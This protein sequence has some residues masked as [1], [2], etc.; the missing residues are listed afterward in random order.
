MLVR[1]L[2]P[3]RPSILAGAL[4]LLPATLDAQRVLGGGDDAVTLPRGAF[5]VELGGLS[6]LQR[7]RWID[8]R[9]EGLGGHLTADAFGP[10]QFSLLAPVEQLVRDLGVP[11]FAASLGA[12]RLDARQRLFVTPLTIEYGLGARVTVGAR[13]TLVRSRAQAQWRVRGDSGRATLGMNPILAGSAVAVGNATTIGAYASA[14]T[15]L[16]ARRTACQGNPAAA[17]ECPTILAELGAVDALIATTSG[18]AS[19]LTTLYGAGL[20]AGQRFVPMA[21][22]ATEA[23]LRARADSMRLALERYGIT[24]VTAGTGLPLGAQVPVAAADLARLLTDSTWGYGARPLNDAGIIELGDVHLSAKLQLFDS[25]GADPRARF[26]AEARGWRQS[27][28]VDVRL[29]AGTAERPDAFLDLGTG[30]GTTAVSVR[31]IT[32]VVWDARLWGTVSVGVTQ[33]LAHDAR[34]RVPSPTGAT[35]WLEWWR[36]ADVRVTPGLEVEVALAPRWH[37]SDYIALGGQWRWRKRAAWTHEYAGTATT[38]FGASVP[39]DARRLDEG[40]ASSA[41]HAALSATY[42]TLAGLARGRTGP[43]FEISYTHDQAIAGNAGRVVKQFEDR[44]TV[45]YYTRFLAR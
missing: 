1:P 27:L 8:G 6:T 22:S 45:R 12:S 29:G 35:E 42:S 31:S 36:E 10:L 19:G 26:A 5:R 25:F 44:L 7:D 20:I 9:L 28:L 4:L 13:A 11:G 16:G 34:L 21:G 33:A 32:D 30:T 18:F 3:L 38:P 39:L 37:L 24:D 17:P 15:N 41:Q 23:A 2:R 43:A 40:T 14:A